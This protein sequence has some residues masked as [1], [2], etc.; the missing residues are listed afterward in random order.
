MKKTFRFTIQRKEKEEKKPSYLLL[1][2]ED[3]K[4][5]T[6]KD[7]IIKILRIKEN[8]ND[9]QE[10]WGIIEST[11]SSLLYFF[12]TQTLSQM[13]LE[14]NKNEIKKRIEEYLDSSNKRRFYKKDISFIYKRNRIV[15]VVIKIFDGNTNMVVLE[16][17]FYKKDIVT[18]LERMFIR[19]E[20]LIILFKQKAESWDNEVIE[21]FMQNIR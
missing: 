13:F 1:L 6:L 3:L 8:F 4:R 20:N 2:D 16:K 18:F 14:I 11:Q 12:S 10:L 9:K 5:K 17:S 19:E 15:S 7:S 21:E